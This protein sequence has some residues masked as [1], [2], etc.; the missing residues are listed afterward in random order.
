MLDFFIYRHSPFRQHK[1]KDK[2]EIDR[3]TLTYVSMVNKK[4]STY[5]LRTNWGQ[6]FTSPTGDGTTILRGDPRH[7]RSSCLHGKGSNF[8]SQL[9]EDTEYWSGPG[10]QTRDLPLCSQALYRLS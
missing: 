6:Y 9:F 4:K 5:T 2:H 3:L 1:T 10:N 8:I 7:E